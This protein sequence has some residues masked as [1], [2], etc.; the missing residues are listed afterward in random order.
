[1]IAGGG[2][3]WYTPS[4][5]SKG[6]LYSGSRTRTRSAGTRAQPNGGAFAGPA[7]YT[8]SAGPSRWENRQAALVSTR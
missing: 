2:G 7:L 3:A 6:N 8:D 1:M 4:L 5:D